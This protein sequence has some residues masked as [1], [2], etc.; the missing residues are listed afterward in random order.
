MRRTSYALYV[1]TIK[2]KFKTRLLCE[3]RTVDLVG[4]MERVNKKRTRGSRGIVSRL[5]DGGWT[6]LGSL[7]PTN[8]GEHITI[9]VHFSDKPSLS[10]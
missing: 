1:I 3:G 9:V 10:F 4:S 2:K 8:L 5:D 7:G 6:D